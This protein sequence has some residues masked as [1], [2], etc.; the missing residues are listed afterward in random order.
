MFTLFLNCKLFSV[1]FSYQMKNVE[2]ICT[3]ELT[4]AN[5]FP[6]GAAVPEQHRGL[7]HRCFYNSVTPRITHFDTERK[8]YQFLYQTPFFCKFSLAAPNLHLCFFFF[9]LAIFPLCS[10]PDCTSSWIYRFSSTCVWFLRLPNLLEE[11]CQWRTGQ[12]KVN[13][14]QTAPKGV[15]ANHTSQNPNHRGN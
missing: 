7:V 13:P 3:L 6:L 14:I 10:S 2:L 1:F 15:L 5:S 11:F 8:P 9:R 4:R 12:G